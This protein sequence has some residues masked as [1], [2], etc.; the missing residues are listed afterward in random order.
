MH[1]LA[2][3][4]VIICVLLLGYFR[5]RLGRKVNRA[6]RKRNEEGSGNI[7]T[8]PIWGSRARRLRD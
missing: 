1:I 6:A 5:G 4:L 8:R 3:V 7:L 2:I